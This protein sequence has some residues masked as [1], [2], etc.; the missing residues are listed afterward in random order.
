ML[1]SV[2]SFIL[3]SFK[4]TYLLGSV[5]KSLIKCL[6]LSNA[7]APT[8]LNPALFYRAWPS[9]LSAAVDQH[10]DMSIISVYSPYQPLLNVSDDIHYLLIL[11]QL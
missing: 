11:S 5:N 10:H 6:Q 4:K 3:E 8:K 2:M 7:A 1:M 9:K